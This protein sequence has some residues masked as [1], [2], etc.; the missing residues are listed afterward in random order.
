MAIGSP[1]KPFM[2][3][4]RHRQSRWKIRRLQLIK[5]QD[6][7]DS[8]LLHD[9]EMEVITSGETRM[10]EY[11]F[12]GALYCRPVNCEYLSCDA[13]QCV[14]GRLNRVRATDGDVPVQNLL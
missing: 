13:E 12:L 8:V 14:E 9:C 10:A 5:A 11:H 7:V 1:R 4:N 3:E 6:T 2:T